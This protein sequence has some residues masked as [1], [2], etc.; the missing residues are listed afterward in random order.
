MFCN[1]ASLFKGMELQ[2]IDRVTTLTK[3]EFLKTISSPKTG[4]YWTICG[5]LACFWKVEP[6]LHEGGSRRQDGSI[7]RRPPRGLII[8]WLQRA[9]RQNEDGRLH[10]LA[11][12]E[13]T[14]YR[15]FF[16]EHPKGSSELQGRLFLSRFWAETDEGRLCCFL[17]E[18]SYTFMHYDIDLAN[19]FHFH[20]HGKKQVI[21]FDQDQNDYLYTRSCIRWLFVRT[22]ILSDPD[23]EKMA[24]LNRAKGDLL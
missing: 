12:K 20:F 9:P 4:H 16:V 23:Y 19:I 14:C 5:R 7:V 10:R 1:F 8:G 24:G 11:E 3:E 17:E 2:Q 21:L 18:D 13:P 15:I 22:S 6:R